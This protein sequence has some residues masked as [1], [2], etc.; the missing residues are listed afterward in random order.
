MPLS[1]D[2]QYTSLIIDKKILQRGSQVVQRTIFH[3]SKRRPDRVLAFATVRLRAQMLTQSMIVR[4][5]HAQR[6]G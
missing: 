6:T 3:A 2:E 5:K 1:K 4:R